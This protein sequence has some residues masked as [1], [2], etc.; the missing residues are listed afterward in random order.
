MLI[1]FTF[2]WSFSFEFI[3]LKYCKPT[4]TAI[5]A[6]YKFIS[7]ITMVI[8][9]FSTSSFPN[10]TRYKLHLHYH[11]VY[12]CCTSSQLQLNIPQLPPDV[13][14]VNGMYSFP[15]TNCPMVFTILCGVLTLNSFMKYLYCYPVIFIKLVHSVFTFFLYYQIFMP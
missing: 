5:E 8:Y 12:S 7:Y 10:I 6:A 13:L 11:W 15:H 3:I 1:S 2:N 9:Y 14:F 4:I